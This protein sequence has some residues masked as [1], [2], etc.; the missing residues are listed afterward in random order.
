V[1]KKRGKLGKKRRTREHIIADLG[2]NFVERHILLK[3]HSSQIIIR[4]YGFDLVMYTYSDNGEIENGHI[5]LQVKST[6][7]LI[8]KKSGTISFAVELA[9]L[10]HWFYE[11]LPIIFVVYDAS[12][13]EGNAYWI[14][15]QNYINKPENLEKFAADE[16]D[17][18]TIHIPSENRLNGLAVE[19]FRRFRDLVLAQVKGV[20]GHD[21]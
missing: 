3:G 11:P 1:S 14:Y 4:D 20:I 9:H 8:I 21:Y 13:T 10:K 19:E 12:T 5:H 15:V 6:D 18:I 7:K 2:V 16:Q 17:T